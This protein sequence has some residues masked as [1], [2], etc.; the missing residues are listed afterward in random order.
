[1]NDDLMNAMLLI[2]EEVLDKLELTAFD[3][4]S[5][6]YI[7]KSLAAWRVNPTVSRNFIFHF[8]HIFH[9]NMTAHENN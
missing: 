7:S 1:M 3:E 5:R 2:V 8:Y 9:Y 6:I 4:S